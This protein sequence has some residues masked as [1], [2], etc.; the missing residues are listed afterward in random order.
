MSKRKP[1]IRQLSEW[2]TIEGEVDATAPTMLD[3]ARAIEDGTLGAKVP[4]SFVRRL[5]SAF[6][7][8]EYN[9]G[10]LSEALH[11]T[12]DNERGRSAAA[13]KQ[14]AQAAVDLSR[15]MRARDESE[16]DG[17][18]VLE[19][20]K[21]QAHLDRQMLL[22][23]PECGE[24]HVDVGEFATKEHHTHA[25]QKCGHTWRPAICPTF[26]VQ[27]LPGFKNGEPGDR[28]KPPEQ[29]LEYTRDPNVDYS[30]GIDSILEKMKS[31]GG[32]ASKSQQIREQLDR[33]HD[34]FAARAFKP[35]PRI[36]RD[37]FSMTDDEA[38]ALG[39]DPPPR[40]G[41]P[42]SREPWR[43]RD[44]SLFNELDRS[45]RPEW[46]KEIAETFGCGYSNAE[47]I[48][49]QA[50]EA[51]MMIEFKRG[52]EGKPTGDLCE[53]PMMM[54]FLDTRGSLLEAPI[55]FGPFQHCLTFLA[56]WHASAKR[57]AERRNTRFR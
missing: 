36:P 56:G 11:S 37:P 40:K 21:K 25:C 16:K 55:Y 28:T 32:G 43:P 50:T 4:P 1:K 38:R 39:L 7:A 19:A 5:A 46:W 52:Q 34:S 49:R 45:R 20:A 57:E 29:Q 44:P 48:D 17:L 53:G 10:R 9:S 2:A 51:G 41:D 15:E 54:L 33:A 26:G 8:F 42:I 3:A 23:C 14:L 27:F 30:G 24:R 18:R 35:L 13:E 22:W 6:V 12:L 31:G 47:Q